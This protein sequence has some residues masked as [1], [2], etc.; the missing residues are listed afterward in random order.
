MLIFH[1]PYSIPIQVVDIV[2]EVNI[3]STNGPLYV[4]YELAELGPSSNRRFIVSG[5]I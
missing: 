1:L 5:N 3:Y 2:K 4:R